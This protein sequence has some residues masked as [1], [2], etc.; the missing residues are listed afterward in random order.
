MEQAGREMRVTDIITGHYL[1]EGDQLQITLEAVDVANNRTVW[2]DTLNVGAA[3]MIALRREIAAKVRQG[4]VPALGAGDSSAEAATRPKNEEA[5]DL[6]LRS[7]SLAH[8]AAPDREA[9]CHAGAVRRLDATYAPT[10]RALGERYYYDSHYSGGGEAM[11]ERSTL[12]S[13]GR[14][15]S[16][17]T[18][19]T[20]P[21]NSL[22][23]EWRELNWARRIRM[24]RLWWP[25]IQR[26]RWRTLP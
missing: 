18:T 13:S 1:K 8:D 17:R 16:T 2:R 10:W 21:G 4:L 3:D 5:Y 25:G 15:L 9:I 12:S 6:Y 11:F 26:M 24:R 14:L 19:A 22:P 20:R 7:V 23:I